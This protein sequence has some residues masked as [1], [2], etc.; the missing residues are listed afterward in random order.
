LDLYKS[1]LKKKYISAFPNLSSF[2]DENELSLKEDLNADILEHLE[3]LKINFSKYFSEDYSNKNWI[4]N[5]FLY[6]SSDNEVPDDVEDKQSFIDMVSDSSMKD[7]FKDKTLVSFWMSTK[8]EYPSLFKQA[9]QC[10]T[11]FV[12]TYLCESGFSE[13]LYLK[14]KYRNRLD[15]QND[16]RVKISSIQPD[17]DVLVQNKQQ[18]IS[19]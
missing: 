15:I 16:L 12:T 9:L 5:P 19:H 6:E 14:N 8:K 18:Q 3:A 1:Q 11:P 13:L 17:I 10:L 2:I 4:R 7:A